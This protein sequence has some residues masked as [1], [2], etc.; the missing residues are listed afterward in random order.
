MWKTIINGLF[1]HV[2]HV[3]DEV[4]DK[5]DFLWTEEEKGKFEIDFNN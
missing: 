4:V 5:S 3:N 1:I 2:Y